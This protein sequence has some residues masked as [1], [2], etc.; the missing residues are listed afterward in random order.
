ME[1]KENAFAGVFERK[2]TLRGLARK[3]NCALDVLCCFGDII[4]GA[5][6]D[7]EADAESIRD[8]YERFCGLYETAKMLCEEADNDLFA[9][10]NT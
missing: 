8:A 6:Y 10:L 7:E 9:A 1:N 2:H 3:I 5:I 4:Q